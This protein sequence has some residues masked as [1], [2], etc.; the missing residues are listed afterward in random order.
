MTTLEFFVLLVT[1]GIIGGIVF[2]TF[3]KSKEAKVTTGSGGN[4]EEPKPEEEPKPIEDPEP[5]PKPV[6]NP[7]V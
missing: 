3:R 6:E 7:M 5:D 1:L 4:Y 2:L